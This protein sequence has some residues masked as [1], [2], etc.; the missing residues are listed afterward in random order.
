MQRQQLQLDPELFLGRHWQREHLLIRDAIPGFRPGV[1]ADELAGLAMEDEIESR[2]IE[3]LT[4]RYH[5]F[6]GPFTGADFQR[7]APWTLLVQG[8]DRYVPE[9]A[10]LLDLVKFIPRWRLDDI[11]VS[12]AVDGG[13]VGPHYDNYDVFLLQGE[14]ERHW[15]IGPLCDSSTPLMPDSELRILAEF[16]C[17]AEYTLTKGDILYVPPGVAHWGVAV[18]ECTTFSIGFRAPRVNDMVSRWADHVLEQLDPELFYRDYRAAPASRAGEI[19]PADLQRARSQLLG[20]LDQVD[21]P[22][23]FGE[24]VTEQGLGD[25]PDDVEQRR[26]RRQLRSDNCC[27]QLQPGARIAWQQEAEG[28]TVFAN[29]QV[30]CFP[31]TALPALVTLCERTVLS[32]TPGELAGANNATGELLSHLFQCGCINVK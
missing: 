1:S 5:Q 11:M 13:G 26:L 14:G 23:W 16:S 28:I 25:T 17:E 15:Q 22:H 10:A 3:Y 27:V 2:I 32:L 7:D 12:Y 9:V 19:R 21:A 31:E 29:G 30:D 20:A 8:V 6:K 4:P 24:L 18:G